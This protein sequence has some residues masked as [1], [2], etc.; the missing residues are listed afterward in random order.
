MPPRL[1]ALGVG[2]SSPFTDHRSGPATAFS[3]TNNKQRTPLAEG[4][5]GPN[6]TDDADDNY[7]ETRSG[8]AAHRFTRSVLSDG[9]QRRQQHQQQRHARDY[10]SSPQQSGTQAVRVMARNDPN[11]SLTTKVTPISNQHQPISTTRSGKYTGDQQS[12]QQQQQQQRTTT[13]TNN[14]PTTPNRSRQGTESTTSS[15]HSTVRTPTKTVDGLTVGQL[16][17]ALVHMLQVR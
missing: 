11:R 1:T 4:D 13:T 2:Y 14:L 5:F 9:Q 6:Y 16:R 17:E 12:K 7:D 3:S 15:S 10:K 8:S